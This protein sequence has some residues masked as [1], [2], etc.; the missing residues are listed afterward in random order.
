[1]LYMMVFY[2]IIETFLT[3]MCSQPAKSYAFEAISCWNFT[4]SSVSLFKRV[5]ETSSQGTV[6]AACRPRLAGCQHFALKEHKDATGAWILGGN[7]NGLVYFQVA[8]M[9]VGKDIVPIS[10]VLYIDLSFIKRGILICPYIVSLHD[11]F[12]AISYVILY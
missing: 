3:Q 6:G 5:E 11:I 10:I 1:M 8:E 7:A 12:H 4:F 9:R 2:M